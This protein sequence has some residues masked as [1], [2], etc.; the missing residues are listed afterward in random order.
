MLNNVDNNDRDTNLAAVLHA[1]GD[2]RLEERE[3]PL[4]AA[5]EVLVKVEAVGIC[6]SDVHYYREGR[7]GGYVV[8]QP[9]VLGHESS[10]T[11]VGLGTDVTTLSVGD[12]VT[13]EPG[14]SCGR[15]EQCKKGRYN[16]CPAVVFFATPPID[17]AFQ[18]YVSVRADFVFPIPD[19]MSFEQGAL[20]EPL[21]V[22]VWACTKA[23]VTVGSRVLVTGAGP[24]GLLTLQ[25]ALAF[26][27]ESVTVTD[28]DPAKLEIARSLGATAVIDA[29]ALGEQPQPLDADVHIECSG[30]PTAALQGIGHLGRGGTSV[31]VGMGG[32]T[33]LGL[34]V[35]DVQE[36]ELTITGTFRYANCYP[37]AIQLLASGKVRIDELITARMSLADTESA[38][39][40]GAQAGSLKAL[41]FPNQ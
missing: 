7:I 21:A 8:E 17:G 3:T 11:V 36:R 27:A 35:A 20:V 41:V 10:G 32:S 12:R 15:C 23:A 31:L 40:S 33:P 19:S 13:I 39:Q 25:T 26:G 37:A 2:I 38:L 4:P 30:N 18:K 34:T 6:G 14:V 29:R 22:A 16:L 1:P 9:L 24:I 5:D 28:I